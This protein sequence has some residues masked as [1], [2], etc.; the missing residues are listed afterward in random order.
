MALQ[1]IISPQS[2]CCPLFCPHPRL[3][4]YLSAFVNAPTCVFLSNACFG[5]V[6]ALEEFTNTLGKSSRTQPKQKLELLES[7]KDKEQRAICK[8]RV[9]TSREIKVAPGPLVFFPRKRG[10]YESI[11][12]KRQGGRTVTELTSMALEQDSR[13]YGRVT[14]SPLTPTPRFDVFTFYRSLYVDPRS[15]VNDSARDVPL[16]SF[17]RLDPVVD[18]GWSRWSAW[19]VCGTDCTH[20][21]RRSCDEPT[22]SHGGR[23]C[24]GRETSLAN[25]TG[26]MCSSKSRTTILLDESK[27]SSRLSLF[28]CPTSACVSK[29]RMCY[30]CAICPLGILGGGFLCLLFSKVHGD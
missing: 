11:K 29:G 17:S 8:Y 4:V 25:C 10:T 20:T 23:P 3:T 19:S 14:R 13:G 1:K 18:G 24:Q 21:R 30:S 5:T 16:C 22:P 27:H 28:R 7:L 15:P 2:D 12:T 26:G 6:G 9:A